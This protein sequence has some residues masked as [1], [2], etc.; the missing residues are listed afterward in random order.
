MIYFFKNL[1]L[2]AL[3]DLFSIDEN[4]IIENFYISID[5]LQNIESINAVYLLINIAFKY[6]ITHANDTIVATL[7]SY[8]FTTSIDSR[9]N[10]FEFKELLIDFDVVV[11]FTK[12]I[13]QLKALQK[14]I[15]VKLDEITAELTNFVCEIDSIFFID[16][17]NL[18]TLID[19]IVCHIVQINI[20]FLL[21][22]ADMIKL[23][24]FFNNITNKIIQFN[25]SH[26]VIRRYDHAFLL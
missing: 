18:N 11:R 7:V 22:L 6:R 15:H 20:L 9:Y 10:K 26:S 8:S 12:D 17:I 3:K 24:A 2:D 5:I 21:C 1:S 4:T 16:T 25:H 19:T 23:K 13:N 14:V